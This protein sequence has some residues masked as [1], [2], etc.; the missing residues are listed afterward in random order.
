M[1]IYLYFFF[2]SN[3]L[4]ELKTPDALLTSDKVLKKNV[5]GIRLHT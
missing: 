5:I 4:K 1:S 3:Y 2:F